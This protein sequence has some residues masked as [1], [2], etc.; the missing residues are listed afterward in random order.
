MNELQKK[1]LRQIRE[2]LM[3]H[4]DAHTLVVEADDINDQRDFS[5]SGSFDGPRSRLIG[6][7]EMAKKELLDRQAK[8]ERSWGDDKED[9]N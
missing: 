4:F 8:D 3:E 2:L 6:M 9:D 7:C 5:Q 1:I